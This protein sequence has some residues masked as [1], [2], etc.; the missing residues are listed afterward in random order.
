MVNYTL[1][2]FISRF[3]SNTSRSR[4]P[5]PTHNRVPVWALEEGRD[6]CTQ[7]SPIPRKIGI[8]SILEARGRN[9]VNQ[10]SG[11]VISS[12]TR[13]LTDSP[14]NTNDPVGGAR[15]FPPPSP[16]LGIT[17]AP[18]L[19]CAAD[20]VGISSILSFRN[21]KYPLH[22]I[23]MR[24]Q[25]PH[26]YYTHTHTS[27]YN[28]RSKLDNAQSVIQPNVMLSPSTHAHAHTHTLTRDWWSVYLESI[29]IY[30]YICSRFIGS[31]GLL[32]AQTS[33][34]RDEQSEEYA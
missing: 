24:T 14:S 21:R 17:C 18:V 1:Q 15:R 12:S 16:S 13:H 32:Y 23:F 5:L 26:T 33:R 27:R 29:H 7:T 2:K 4:T 10:A 11:S 20:L 19:V 31:M 22:T 25:P 34:H 8:L 30:I 6:H 9:N 28:I 3:L